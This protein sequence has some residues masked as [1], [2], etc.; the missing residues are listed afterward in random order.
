MA[1]FAKVVCW[2]AT[3]QTVIHHWDERRS[4]RGSVKGSLWGTK[5]DNQTAGPPEV[6]PSVIRPPPCA[7]DVASPTL[8]ERGT[9]EKGCAGAACFVILFGCGDY[10]AN[11]SGPCGMNHVVVLFCAGTPDQTTNVHW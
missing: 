9:G 2:P 4:P 10:I 11:P 8:G 3:Y 1:T 5:C 6:L 7:I